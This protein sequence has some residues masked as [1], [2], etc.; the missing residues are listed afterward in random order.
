[1][2]PEELGAGIPSDLP[3]E[4]EPEQEPGLVQEG[5]GLLDTFQNEGIMAGLGQTAEMF[6]PQTI[7]QPGTV[8]LDTVFNDF[9]NFSVVGDI[10]DVRAGLDPNSGLDPLERGLSLLPL[11]T[12]LA[13]GALVAGHLAKARTARLNAAQTQTALR[14]IESM[15]TPEGFG[16][17]PDQLPDTPVDQYDAPTRRRVAAIL[18]QKAFVS[19]Q[20]WAERYLEADDFGELSELVTSTR[21]PVAEAHLRLIGTKLIES[22]PDLYMQVNPEDGQLFTPEEQALVAAKMAMTRYE[23]AIQQGILHELD[24]AGNL[25]AT[26]FSSASKALREARQSEFD[27]AS[28]IDEVVALEQKAA[29]VTVGPNWIPTPQSS[30]RLVWLERKNPNDFA[31]TP[32]MLLGIDLLPTERLYNPDT[33][34]VSIKAFQKRFSRI[35]PDA[36]QSDMAANLAQGYLRADQMPGNVIQAG[37]TWYK[38]ANRTAEVLSR[39]TGFKQQRVTGLMSAL[40]PQTRWSPDN[41]IASIHLIL[42]YKSQ[43]LDP[44]SAEYRAVVREAIEAGGW[45]HDLRDTMRKDQRA[46][47]D[48]QII[49]FWSDPANIMGTGGQVRAMGMRDKQ[50]AAALML[51]S[52]VPWQVILRHTKTHTFGALMND[53]SL[54]ESSVIDAHSWRASLGSY[55]VGDPISSGATRNLKAGDTYEFEVSG[56]QITDE[57]IATT[58]AELERIGAPELISRYTNVPGLKEQRLYEV[59]EAAHRTVRDVFAVD[60]AHQAQAVVWTEQ[61]KRSKKVVDQIKAIRRRLR[62]QEPGPRDA[63]DLQRLLRALTVDSTVLGHAEGNPQQLG[64]FVAWTA[65]ASENLDVTPGPAVMRTVGTKSPILVEPLDDGVAVYGKD[66][67][68]VYEALRHLRPA[69]VEAG[70]VY[71]RFVPRRV[72]VVEDVDRVA[73]R[74]STQQD[75]N[76]LPLSTETRTWMGDPVQYVGTRAG[77]FMVFE[78]DPAAAQELRSEIQGLPWAFDVIEQPV[79]VARGGAGQGA[80]D[81]AALDDVDWHEPARNPLTRTSWVAMTAYKGDLSAADNSR[82]QAE[83]RKAVKRSGGT[84]VETEGIYGGEVEPSLFI[85]GLSYS[86]AVALAKKFDQES[87]ATPQGLL[88]SDGTYAPSDG[89]P[90]FTPGDGDRTAFADGRA[91]SWDYGDDPF[92]PL[93][94]EMLPENPDDLMGFPEQGPATALVVDLGP[95]GTPWVETDRLWKLA[96]QHRGT[97]SSA[98]YVHG[99][100]YQPAG[101]EATYE[102]SYSDTAGRV[103]TIRTRENVAG[104][105]SNQTKVYIPSREAAGLS[106]KGNRH[107]APKRTKSEVWP[108]VETAESGNA[109]MIPDEVIVRYP[110]PPKVR[111]NGTL[112]TGRAPR[113]ITTA[114]VDLTGPV[115]VIEMGEAVFTDGIA[116]ITISDEKVKIDATNPNDALKVHDLMN[117][118]G[119]GVRGRANIGEPSIAFGFKE[120]TMATPGRRSMGTVFPGDI[121]VMPRD[122]ALSQKAGVSVTLGRNFSDTQANLVAETVQRLLSGSYPSGRPVPPRTLAQLEHGI[123]GVS[124]E[125]ADLRPNQATYGSVPITRTNAKAIYLNDRVAY[126]DQQLKGRLSDIR[127]RL[128]PDVHRRM[129]LAGVDWLEHTV[130]HEMGHTIHAAAGA[131]A[132]PL[133]RRRVERAIQELGGVPGVRHHISA[134]A[135]KDGVEMFADAYA[136]YTVNP[137]GL[138]PA[139]K[140]MVEDVLDLVEMIPEDG[141]FDMALVPDGILEKFEMLHKTEHFPTAPT[142]FD[143]GGAPIPFDYGGTYG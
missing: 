5:G 92:D 89:D 61:Q 57:E 37:S 52:D 29:K 135:V 129:R 8:G 27:T 138:H 55:L 42:R 112:L 36:L 6:T 109:L 40:S 58:R 66:D 22:N 11:V 47:T 77:N 121:E 126:L 102:H 95:N 68:E 13:G 54:R 91:F 48:E 106:T 100:L 46:M 21:N 15:A 31:G 86:K 23:A 24:A 3:I 1:M 141:K 82:R 124:Y 63:A 25:N 9:V 105:S 127:R 59:I 32:R 64:S 139:A 132:L 38:R 26:S 70:S 10:F 113:T 67:P 30:T 133:V 114:S 140:S 72:Q 143:Y 123:M 75:N 45:V 12:P 65:N 98:A 7:T 80:W 44:Y 88:F 41:L 2:D 43:D 120:G 115:P 56:E 74:V 4:E 117:R 69:P 90:S 122:A 83:L 76:G 17:L 119:M 85:T 110:E 116:R 39:A 118:I 62:H 99:A 128:Y 19:E 134:Y 130:I 53:P 87:I 81:V 104:E 28:W 79:S 103:T 50:I 51:F 93:N 71:S 16:P 108:L 107:V 14:G 96:S 78:V 20:A 33:G 60:Q 18:E 125:T 35:A 94:R 111:R 34:A 136:L 73:K 142:P 84:V 49:E 97:K 101:T 137:D 131:D